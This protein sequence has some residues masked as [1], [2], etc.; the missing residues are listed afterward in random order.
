MY[1]KLPGNGKSV[2][3]EPYIMPLRRKPLPADLVAFVLAIVVSSDDTRRLVNGQ[4]GIKG[5]L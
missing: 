1:K 5:I 2:T 3:G 4:I